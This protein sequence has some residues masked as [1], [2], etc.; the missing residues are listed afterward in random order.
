M[1]VPQ[2]GGGGWGPP[3][4]S[5]PAD[6]PSVPS[7]DLAARIEEFDLFFKKVVVMTPQT[8]PN[9]A[10]L[11]RPLL[12]KDPVISSRE[13]DIILGLFLILSMENHFDCV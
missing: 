2:K 1:E 12:I 4:V 5:A 11:I 9:P 3:P 6:V 10:T 7:A 8:A 13:F